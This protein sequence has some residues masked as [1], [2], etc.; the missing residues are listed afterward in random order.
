MAYF[1][2]LVPCYVG[3]TFRNADDTFEYN[4]PDN[5]NLEM[6]SGDDEKAEDVKASK[7]KRSAKSKAE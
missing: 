5:T 4:G 2:A 1:R 7:P 6:I 3:N